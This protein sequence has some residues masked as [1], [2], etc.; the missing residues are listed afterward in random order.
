MRNF[1]IGDKV[2]VV[3]P[4]A[5]LLIGSVHVVHDIRESMGC[6]YVYLSESDKRLHKGWLP[7]QFVKYEEKEKEMKVEMGKKYRKVCMHE[8]VRVLCVDRVTEMDYIPVIALIKPHDGIE[9]CFYLTAEGYTRDGAQI[10][11]EVPS[12]DWS[13]V[14]CDTPIWVKFS[15]AIWHKRHFQGADSNGVYF[16]PD[17]KTSFTCDF[18]THICSCVNRVAFEDCSLDAPE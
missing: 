4:N 16:W 17:G 2:I 1:E 10:I 18:P 9:Q 8:P 7:R 11:E 12:V 3:E 5:A 6:T 13:K 14:K 15:A